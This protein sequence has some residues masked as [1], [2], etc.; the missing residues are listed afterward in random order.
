MAKKKNVKPEIP[1]DVQQ[2]IEAAPE[3]K[4]AEKPKKARTEKK[5]K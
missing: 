2:S 5:E 1:L 3:E 4:K